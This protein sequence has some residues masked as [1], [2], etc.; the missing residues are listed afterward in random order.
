MYQDQLESYRKQLQVKYE[1]E[2]RLFEEEKRKRLQDIQQSIDKLNIPSAD[3]DRLRQEM[4]Q[5]KN[6][7]R[8]LN[9][10][11]AEIEEEL[12]QENQKKRQL[13]RDI[14]EL[15]IQINSQKAAGAKDES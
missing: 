2:R 14:N 12:D 1:K 6:E 15:S 5:L 7:Q 10:K 9:A 3:K 8:E 11:I 13:E 4:D